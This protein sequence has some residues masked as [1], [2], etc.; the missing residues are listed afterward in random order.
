M[1][2]FGNQ[3]KR[4]TYDMIF[5]LNGLLQEILDDSVVIDV[6]GVGY[7]VMIPSSYHNQLPSPG[8]RIMFYTYHHIRE[9]HEL[10]FGFLSKQ[11]KSFFLK[12]VGVSGVGPKVAL[13]ILSE[14]S[15]DNLTKYILG[16]DLS[17]LIALPGV[18]KKMAERMVMELKDKLDILPSA[19][20]NNQCALNSSYKE[21]LYLALQTLGYSKDEVNRLIKA[22]G[23]DLTH[24]DPIQV[25]IKKVLKHT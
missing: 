12:L 19:D 17:G 2:L 16:N 1:D 22:S 15:I 3:S 20:L 18:G 4:Y 14:Q 23:K 5:S 6:T 9:D 10:L 21:D 7:Q 24:D 25:S 11:E 13:K 8:Q